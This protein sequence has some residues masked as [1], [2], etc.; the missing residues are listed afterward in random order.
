MLVHKYAN[1]QVCKQESDVMDKFLYKIKGFDLG[2]RKMKYVSG[3]QTSKLRT[4][5]H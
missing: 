2:C 4:C 5:Y 3:Q 1:I